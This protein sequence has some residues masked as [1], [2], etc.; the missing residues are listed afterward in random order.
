MSEKPTLKNKRGLLQKWSVTAGLVILAAASTFAD[1][2]FPPYDNTA[3]VEAAWKAKPNFYQF[4]TPADI[5]TDLV[6]ETGADLPEIGDPEAKKGGTFHTEIPSFPPTLRFVGPDG[7]NTFRGEHAD[8][9]EMSLVSRHPNVDKWIPGIAE[10]W[11]LSKDRLTVYYRLDPEARYSDGIKVTVEDFFMAFYMSLS[12]YIV[13]PYANDY[14]SREFSAITKYD[15]RT[16]SITLA[17]PKPDPIYSA[18]AGPYPRH[19]FREFGDDFPARYQWRKM[20]TTGAYDIAPEDIK[21]GRSI[22]MTRVKDWWARDKKYYRY[23]FNADLLEYRVITSPDTAWELFRQG[24][25]DF[26]SNRFAA[27]PPVYW[28]DKGEIPEL[29]NGYIERGTFFNIYPRISRGIYV[30]QSKL[31]LDNQDIRLGINYSLNFEKV[32]AVVLR[33]DAVRM[34]ST[35]AGFGRFT[36][37]KLRARPFDVAKAQEHFAKAGYTK[38]GGDGVLINAEGK[39]LSFTLSVPNQAI[40]GQAALI[41]KE[42]ALKSGLELRIEVLD[43]TQLYKKGDQ[44]MHELIVCGWGASPPYPRSWEYYHSVNAWEIKPD[45]SKKVK[46]DTNN[47][48]MTADPDLD[49]LI[50][51]HRNAPNEEEMQ[52]LSWIIEEK[53]EERACSIPAW[54]SPFYR[55]MHW[56]WMRWPKDGNVKAS[57]MPLESYVYWID[58][59]VKTETK[60]AQAEGKSFGEVSRV[61]DQYREP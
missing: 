6:W 23:R 55:Y 60:K 22:T 61:F 43:I 33:G 31:P 7:S 1:D 51:Q 16:L 27:L 42:D 49:V 34:Q 54:D 44:K 37:P 39:R 36:N 21:F 11:A 29:L 59:D 2:R 8:N 35:F 53:I 14:F 24:K 47:F 4:K 57:Q 46:T 3:E 50:D 56:R 52:R 9:V 5:P 18:N 32:I 30:N 48:T 15:D 13:D 40:F 10:S 38:R 26:F 58:E 20:P 19:F 45:G 12:P 25:I 41:L 17:K 28:Y